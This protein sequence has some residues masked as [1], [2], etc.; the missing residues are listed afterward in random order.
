[1]ATPTRYG[2]PIGSSSSSSGNGRSSFLTNLLPGPVGRVAKDVTGFTGGLTKNFLTDIVD[3][4]TGLPMGIVNMI[5]HPIGTAEAIGQGY[6]QTYSPFFKGQIGKGLHNVY[7][8]PLGPLL[9][10]AAVF[11]GGATLAARSGTTL[12]KAGVISAERG[13]ALNSLRVAK[14]IKVL[15]PT[16]MERLPAFKHLSHRPGRRVL[17]NGMMGLEKHLLTY[18][19]IGGNFLQNRAKNRQVRQYEKLNRVRGQH[20]QAILQESKAQVAAISAG[21]EKA[22]DETFD[23]DSYNSTF[24][25][26]HA[27]LE[28]ADTLLDI[29]EVGKQARMHLTEQQWATLARHGW[30]TDEATAATHVGGGHVRYVIAPEYLNRPMLRQI[31]KAEKKHAR[32]TRQRST[33]IAEARP[34]ME[35]WEAELNGLADI[36]KAEPSILKELNEVNARL[37]EIN[38][39]GVQNAHK[40]TFRSGPRKGQVIENPN[41]K[42]RMLY[43]H[44]ERAYLQDVV[45]DLEGRREASIKAQARRAEL[46]QKLND[47]RLQMKQMDDQVSIMHADLEDL[48]DQATFKHF[49]EAAD[50]H[51]A[52]MEWLHNSGDKLTTKDKRFALRDDQGNYILTSKVDAANLGREAEMTSHFLHAAVHFPTVMWKRLILGYTPRIVTNNA[53]GNWMLYVAQEGGSGALMGMADA[54]R[55]R[56]SQAERTRVFAKKVD[57]L[58][59]QPIWQSDHWLH[60]YFQDEMVDA[61]GRDLELAGST[62][63]ATR[64]AG[65]KARVKA[66]FYPATKALAEDPVRAATIFSALRRI[67]EYKALVKRYR[68]KGLSR[69]AANERAAEKLLAADAK[70]GNGAIRERV[71][72]ESRRL[73]GDYITLTRNETWARDLIPFYLWNRHIVKTTGNMTL[74]QPLRVA[75]GARVGAEGSAWMEENFGDLIRYVQGGIP[76]AVFGLGDMNST[77]QRMLITASLNP[78]ATIGEFAEATEALAIGGKMKGAAFNQLN[79]FATSTIESATQRSLLTGQFTNDTRSIISGVTNRTAESIPWLRAINEIEDVESGIS[80]PMLPKDMT[81]IITGMLGLPLRKADIPTVNKVAKLQEGD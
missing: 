66:G 19:G 75:L 39:A 52:Y 20:N 51:E 73:A 3:T 53:V 72:L 80:T 12:A 35:R 38:E 28:A 44:D 59:K 40:A 60:K 68:E 26:T 4:A 57:P 8:H 67:P 77:R 18:D 27:I 78:F 30:A 25:Q 7:E 56:F 14:D 6:W 55:W 79:P 64:A 50:S 74:N 11:S 42:Q 1:M 69:G 17:Q 33:F 32:Y 71:A 9:D 65:M 10:V 31:D 5:R 22:I 13:A 43:E 21:I 63:K 47:H 36:A 2:K 15:D 54:F 76:L 61:W 41:V 48:K 37:R 45:K 70:Y 29:T 62:A 34:K 24:L 81:S 58:S 16:G 49:A 23:L 46:E